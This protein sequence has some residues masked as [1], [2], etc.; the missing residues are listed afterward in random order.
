MVLSAGAQSGLLRGERREAIAAAARLPSGSNGGG[1]GD[2]IAKVLDYQQDRHVAFSGDV[3]RDHPAPSAALGLQLA[4][5]ADKHAGSASTA[6]AALAHIDSVDSPDGRQLRVS[7]AALG[8]CDV[9]IAIKS[10]ADGTTSVRRLFDEFDYPEIFPDAT[11]ATRKFLTGIGDGMATDRYEQTASVLLG[12]D[13]TAV[14][15][16]ASDGYWD[17]Y[18]ARTQ[19]V[20]QGLDLRQVNGAMRAAIAASVDRGL[21]ADPAG[22]AD[23][24][25]EDLIRQYEEIGLPN[26]DNISATAM[27]VAGSGPRPEPVVIGSIDGSG[28]FGPTEAM[29]DDM[30]ADIHRNHGPSILPETGFGDNRVI[31]RQ[32]NAWRQGSEPPT[33]RPKPTALAP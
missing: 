27:V 21:A 18:A 32:L 5:L 31:A 22:M 16:T 15:F 6:T 28:H 20:G 26:T 19:G 13:D 33:A 2:A 25:V 9:F 14:V 8:D 4:Q 3:W 10:G 1:T 23:H 24:L 11:Q 7:A 30:V 29:V 12:P 17:G